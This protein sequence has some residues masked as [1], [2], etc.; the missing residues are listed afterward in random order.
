MAV[1][2]LH[3]VNLRIVALRVFDGESLLQLATFETPW[4]I[5]MTSPDDG[6]EIISVSQQSEHSLNTLT[7]ATTLLDLRK[8]NVTV[9]PGLID[10]HVH[11]ALVPRDSYQIEA[12]RMSAGEKTLLAQTVLS[13]MLGCGYTTVRV[14]GD[15][16][17][18]CFPS[19][20]CRWASRTLKNYPP[21]LPRIVGAGHYISVTGGG[22][23]LRMPPHLQNAGS[24]VDGLIADGE[25]EMRN[26]VRREIQY[27][28][29]W[30]KVLVSG[31]YMTENDSPM[32]THMSR[33]ELLAVVD[34]AKR[35]GVRVMAHAHAPDAITLAAECGVSSIE[36]GS[37]ISTDGITSLVAHNVYLIPTLYIGDFFSSTAPTEGPLAKMLQIQ[38]ETDAKCWAC[39]RAAAN[40]GVKIAFGTDSV[41][42]DP[43]LNWNEARLMVERLGMSNLQVLRSATSSAASLLDLKIGYIHAQ[44]AADLLI[45]TGNPLEDIASLS[46]P[47]FIVKA[48][49]LVSPQ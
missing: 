27:G 29:D 36:H 37:F 42:W 30:I 4:V 25:Q 10:C 32:H 46:Q 21:I 31:A 5:D 23:D 47:K 12:L 41:G 45:V 44:F 48:G 34:E 2:S 14:A 9:M 16:G 22:G 1:S 40:S 3:K 26:A 28:S 11:P 35:R 8:E 13:T 20:D 17:R 49:G 6:G 18:D 38:R 7:S 43:H 19:F 24:L 15:P 33:S 39:L